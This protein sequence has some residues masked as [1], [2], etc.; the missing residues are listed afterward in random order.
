MRCFADQTLPSLYRF[1]DKCI[2]RIDFQTA[3]SPQEPW[4]DLRPFSRG[5]AASGYG[6]H[7]VLPRAALGAAL[8]AGARRR[9]AVTEEKA[10]AAGDSV[11][12]EV[13]RHQ[14]IR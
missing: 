2:R 5:G 9:R 13:V 4:L 8:P 1:S 3:P 6:H 7:G 12:I 11:G 10:C 14:P